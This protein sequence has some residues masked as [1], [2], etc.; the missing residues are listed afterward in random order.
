MAHFFPSW[1]KTPPDD[2]ISALTVQQ[3]STFVVGLWGGDFGGARLDVDWSPAGGLI[4]LPPKGGRA[5]AGSSITHLHSFKAAGASGSTVEL[6]GVAPG[7]G[8]F[9]QV[10]VRIVAKASGPTPTAREPEWSSA[11]PPKAWASNKGA[12]AMT[13][14]EA[15]ECYFWFRKQ[16]WISLVEGSIRKGDAAAAANWS[17]FTRVSV[18][19]VVSGVTWKYVATGYSPAQLMAEKPF[20]VI[21]PIDVR[22]LVFVVRFSRKLAEERKTTTIWSNGFITANADAHQ[23]G[24]AVD[25]AAW[26]GDVAGGLWSVYNDWGNVGSRPSPPRFRFDDVKLAASRP[27]T[28]PIVRYVMPFFIA[29]VQHRKQTQDDG[30]VGDASSIGSLSSILLPDHLSPQI[31][32][33]HVNHFHLQIGELKMA[34]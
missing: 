26:N 21:G 34:T 15:R 27:Q 4:Q 8:R 5:V 24:R 3:G 23:A 11:D 20:A 30:V 32:A 9:A 10:N 14:D 7:G 18:G 33:A 22:L 19:P 28:G 2:D 13:I 17:D 29:N 16:G 12:K 31:A 25:I 1:S 6:Y